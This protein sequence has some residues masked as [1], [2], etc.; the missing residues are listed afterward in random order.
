MIPPYVSAFETAQAEEAEETAARR[1]GLWDEATT[2]RYFLAGGGEASGFAARWE[3]LLDLRQRTATA[4]RAKG[5]TRAGGGPFYVVW[6]R[7]AI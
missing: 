3:A 6:G 2:R 1:I 5:Y 4:I 7:R